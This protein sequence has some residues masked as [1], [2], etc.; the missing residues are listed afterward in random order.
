M[1][2]E[3]PIPGIV[4]VVTRSD[5]IDYLRRAVQRT[6]ETE[7]LRP[8]ALRAGI[9]LGQLRSLAD[10]RAS[11]STTLELIASALG[12]EFYIGPVR[13]E[14]ATQRDV[15]AEI[16]EALGL[17]A[18]ASI[19]DAVGAIHKDAMAA[20]L[21]EGIGRVQEL[22]DRTAAAA[23]LIAAPAPSGSP[24][25]P[26]RHD[27]AV[28]MIP[29]APDVRLAAGT[30]EVAFEES[31]EVS[32]AVAAAALASWARPERLTCVRAAGD[33]MRPTICDGDLVA[34][35]SGRTDPLDGQLFAVRTDAGL[36]V[37]RLR[38]TAGR[39]LLTSDN[40]AHAPRPVAED[41]RILGQIAW[42]GPQGRRD[43]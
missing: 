30:G 43:G 4:S 14:S 3:S 29:V 32:I 18:D 25:V 20:R 26:P 38:L 39:W 9:P 6:I 13:A 40:P 41:D 22:M 16:A 23:T 21:R 42:R 8:F 35:D 10:G 5:G 17:P 37:K 15:P 36:V 28:A 7:G 19:A 2:P 11:R 27:D 24:R 33:S 1:R 34:V 12:L 31:S